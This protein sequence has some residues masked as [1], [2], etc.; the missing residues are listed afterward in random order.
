MAD[1]FTMTN[2]N[3]GEPIREFAERLNKF[4]IPGRIPD[5]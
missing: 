3:P 1:E 4:A 5:I 2:R